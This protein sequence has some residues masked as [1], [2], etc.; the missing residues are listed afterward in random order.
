MRLY[1]IVTDCYCGYEVQVWRTWWPF[2]VAA[3]T[4]THT[5]VEG[6]TAYAERHASRV[7]KYLGQIR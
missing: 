4:N 5:S 6:A 3:G 2:W 1:R 7:V